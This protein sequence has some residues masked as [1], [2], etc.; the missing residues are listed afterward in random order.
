MTHSLKF[1]LPISFPHSLQNYLF[2]AQIWVAISLVTIPWTLNALLC[3]LSFVVLL[4]SL[5]SLFVFCVPE[6]ICYS[7]A[8]SNVTS[9][10][11][12]CYSCSLSLQER[13]ILILLSTKL[14]YGRLMWRHGSI[15]YLSVQLLC[16][17]LPPHK[18]SMVN[19]W[20]Y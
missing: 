18:R 12:L 17:L 20:S 7:R 11:T 3:P 1:S 15:I 10:E 2:K 9:S 13:D 16:I 5:Y 4:Q 14:V 19:E 6:N 8:S